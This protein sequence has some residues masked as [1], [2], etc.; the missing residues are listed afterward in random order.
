M[1]DLSP[2]LGMP[3][4]AL[5]FLRRHGTVLMAAGLL[6]GLALPVLAALLRPALSLLVF[7][8]T[9][10]AFLSVEH[11]ALMAHVR[12]PAL[13][14]LIPA[15]TLLATP[16]LAI[17]CAQVAG[18]SPALTQ[19]LVLWAASPPLAAAPAIAL[20]LGLDG[21]LALLATLGSTFLMPFVLPP[22]VLGLLGL[23]LGVGIVA[24]MTKLAL[25]IGGAALV[26]ALLRRTAGS[27]RLQRHATEIGGIN[28]LL[29]HLFAIAMM[30]GVRDLI[31]AQPGTVLLYVATAFGA[32]VV[33]Q[34][35]SVLAFCRLG[36][37]PALTAG[38]IGG[39]RNMALVFANLGS[40]ATPELTLFF[41]AVQ[42]P[43]YTLPAALRP[44]YR[45]LGT[46]APPSS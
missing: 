16:L 3:F 23:Q 22:L 44:L 10:A 24:L 26:A 20:L 2:G 4:H 18:L 6:V 34:A 37:L 15:W 21:A 7:L 11:P 43:I 25:F 27:P 30:D 5:A 17:A 8:I 36:R 28:V 46:S 41:A 32:N 19:G 1:I 40:A 14:V 39:N 12:R 45:P 42:L 9:I 29:L 13:L 31:L 38:L 35:M 33:F